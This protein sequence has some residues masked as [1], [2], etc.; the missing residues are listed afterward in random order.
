MIRSRLIKHTEH[1]LE[2]KEEKL[3]IQVLHTL[4][5]MMN[6]DSHYGDKVGCYKFHSLAIKLSDPNQRNPSQYHV[7]RAS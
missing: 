3:C 6:F 4:R 2:D 7:Q 5:Q 1:L